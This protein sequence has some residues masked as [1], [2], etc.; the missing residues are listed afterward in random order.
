MVIKTQAVEP[1]TCEQPGCR[2]LE[3][4]DTDEPAETRQIKIAAF[5]RVCAAHTDDVPVG[6]MQWWDGNWKTISEYI[7]YQREFFLRRNHLEWK[8]RFPNNEQPMPAAIAS[9]TVDPVTPGSVAAPAAAKITGLTRAY[10]R[11]RNDNT[12]KNTMLTVPGTVRAGVDTTRITWSYSGTGDSRV[13]TI[14]CGGQ[15]TTQQRNQAQ[16]IA[17]AQYGVGRVI[18]VA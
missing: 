18:V 17:D 3:L 13:L 8:Q 15:L 4:W 5:E 7:A 10:S 12:R 16:S 11:N 2:Y 14:N 6:V 1:D 9:K